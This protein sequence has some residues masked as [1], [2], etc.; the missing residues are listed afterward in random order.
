MLDNTPNQSSKSR[1]KNYV[2]VNDNT[3]GTYNTNSQ[4]RFKTSMLKS[5]LCLYSN[6]YILVRRTIKIAPAPAANTVNDNKDLNC[7]SF[8]DCISETHNTQID[9]SRD[10]D[11]VMSMYNFIEYSNNYSKTAGSLWQYYRNKQFL[12]ANDAIAD[13]P[14]AKINSSSFKFKQKLIG[15]TAD[16]GTKD[17][18][19]LLS[20]KY[21][22]NFWRTLE[23]SFV[24]GEINLILTWSDKCAYYIKL[25]VP[26]VT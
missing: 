2:E 6:A 11:V 26:I 12:D 15:K 17:V 19:I 20:L 24:N 10:I 14:A 18:E 21:V 22:S 1:T 7:V 4:I 3:G 8:T 13:F 23:M 16:V 9:N 25:Y 5:I